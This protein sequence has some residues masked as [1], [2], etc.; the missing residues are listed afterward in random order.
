MPLVTWPKVSGSLLSTHG[1]Y[2][3]A[4]SLYKTVEMKLSIL[5]L[6]GALLSTNFLKAG[7]LLL[8]S[9]LGADPGYSGAKL[10][11]GFEG[12][13]VGVPFSFTQTPPTGFG[14]ALNS[15]SVVVESDD[16]DAA[17]EDPV[18]IAL[19]SDS[20]GLP[21]NELASEVY[22]FNEDY[23]QSTAISVTANF[24]D[25]TQLVP[26]TQ[27]WVVIT[28]PFGEV[29]WYET[30]VAS[31]T[32]G[33]ASQQDSDDG[34]VWQNSSANTPGA[35][36]VYGDLVS[37]APEPGTWLTLGSGIGGLLLLRSRRQRKARC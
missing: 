37:A 26:S 34:P 6:A 29:N 16:S 18:T 15:I 10:S 21:N 5:L 28:D 22:N 12:D 30:N 36:E 19:Y 2:S 1:L 35:V 23:V 9:N 11:D 3:A 24:G 14:Y 25:S 27:Y 32:L 4:D 13:G 33:T 8:Y 17:E 31:P 7:P 20:G